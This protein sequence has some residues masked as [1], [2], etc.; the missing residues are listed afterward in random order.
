MRRRIDNL[1]AALDSAP[2]LHGRQDIKGLLQHLD[3]RDGIVEMLRERG[4]AKTL[5]AQENAHLKFSTT[6]WWETRSRATL[7]GRTRTTAGLRGTS[8]AQVTQSLASHS[9]MI[10]LTTDA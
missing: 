8:L 3:I 2:E 5:Q 10:G 6:P 1:R 7:P 9:W 4:G